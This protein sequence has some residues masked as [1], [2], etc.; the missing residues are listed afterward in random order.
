MITGGRVDKIE[1]KKSSEGPSEGLNINITL[2]DIKT[3]DSTIEILYTYTATYAGGLGEIILN[4]SLTA[5]EDKKLVKEVEEAWEKGK[6]VPDKY[7]EVLINAIN[8]TGSA[9][10]T[11]VARVLNIAPPIVPPR[12]S[13]KK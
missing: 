12:I 5:T 13:F 7:A 10:G 9:N 8:Y 1:A 11:L 2:D 6:K 3:K 4:G